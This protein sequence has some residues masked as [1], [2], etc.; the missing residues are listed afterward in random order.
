V[1]RLQAPLA[2]ASSAFRS[3]SRRG[4][5]AAA[6]LPAGCR[7][8]VGAHRRVELWRRGTAVSPSRGRPYAHAS[9]AVVT[10]TSNPDARDA[11]AKVAKAANHGDVPE[12]FTGTRHVSIRTSTSSASTFVNDEAGSEIPEPA[13]RPGAVMWF[14]Q[15]LRLHDN[16]AF[17]AAVRAAKR[18]GGEVLCVYVWSEREEGDADSSPRPGE[19]S[20]VW[21]R[22]A[23]DALDRDL[24]LKYGDSKKKNARVGL[25]YFKGSHAHALAA[26]CAAVNSSV[27]FAS[28]RFEPAHV[29]GDAR[30]RRFLETNAVAL[31]TLPGH[32][33]FDPRKTTIDMAAE[34]YFFGT[35][36]PY[37]HA[38]EKTGGKP[39]APVPAP[40]SAPIKATDA[41]FDARVAE[42]LRSARAGLEDADVATAADDLDALGILPVSDTERDWSSGI[43]ARW[44]ISESGAEE[45]WEHFKRVNLERYE[46]SSNLTDDDSTAVSRLSPYLR[47]GQISPRR[48]YRELSL[49]ET[50]ETGRRLSRTFWHRLYRREF[51]YWQLT[52]WPDLATRSIRTHYENRNDWKKRWSPNDGANGAR[53]LSSAER[54][55]PRNE[56][57]RKHEASAFDRWR[58]G[59]TGFPAVDVGMRRLWRTGWMHQRERMFAATFLTDYLGIDWRFGA[60][61]FHDTLVDADLAINSMM[62]QNAGKSGLDQWDV[63][64]GSLHPDGSV[65][66]HDPEG[67]AIARWIPE[68]A[69]LPKGH[70]RHRPWDAPRSVLEK[71]GVVLAAFEDVFPESADASRAMRSYLMDANANATSRHDSDGASRTAYPSRVLPDPESSR[72]A[73]VAGVT[74]TRVSQIETALERFQKTLSL[75]ARSEPNVTSASFVTKTTDILVDPRTGADYVVVPAGATRDDSHAG[76]LLPLST[77]KEFKKELRAALAS[78]AQ[79]NAFTMDRLGQWVQESF[80]IGKTAARTDR[81][82]VSTPSD[83]ETGFAR[84]GDVG[85]K[86]SARA[87]KDGTSHSHSHSAGGVEHSHSH[88]GHS[89]APNDAI[90]WNHRGHA[91]GGRAGSSASKKP[92]GGASA[93]GASGKKT[94]VRRSPGAGGST[95]KKGK[96]LK[97]SSWAAGRGSGAA[98]REGEK[99]AERR[100]VKAGRRESRELAAWSSGMRV[101]DVKG[102]ESEEEDE[103]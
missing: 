13:K 56:I 20:R 35:L 95:E 32:L 29:A 75:D 16:Q 24:R 49:S 76:V 12:T 64:S 77:R 2:A 58:Y 21:L 44:E 67:L 87:E 88:G 8:H 103:W 43:R 19:A 1:G 17:H 66:G 14:R 96:V 80:L 57:A 51:A 68:L 100:A 85:E 62:W 92:S 45:A 7:I 47:F 3:P 39:G 18:H 48:L 55:S 59:Q 93:A 9:S 52:K 37:V 41:A 89:H 73:T 102:R 22:H 81:R 65:R 26:A 54:L 71:S 40:P 23:V 60:E 25:T 50:G 79:I 82:G 36:M 42:C 30:V 28:E 33:L 46:D 5:D 10:A 4:I 69:A 15:D 34:K 6:R 53:S 11:N 74:A 99:D 31:I 83:D 101:D 38:A 63:F 91:H 27:V 72:R 90:G 97:S 61:W 94:R 98:R 84:A 86:R 70:W 78:S